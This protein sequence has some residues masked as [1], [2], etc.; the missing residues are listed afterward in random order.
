MRGLLLR[1][2]WRSLAILLFVLAVAAAGGLALRAGL[3]GP[4]EEPSAVA[5]GPEPP[6][7]AP[8]AGPTVLHLPTRRPPTEPGRPHAGRGAAPD[9]GVEYVD[10]ELLV[11]FEDDASPRQ[12]A[13]AVA[14]VDGDLEAHLPGVDVAVVD[15]AAGRTEDAIAALEASPSVEYVE[16]EIVLDGMETLPNDKL[17]QTQ[18]GPKLVQVPAAWDGS[19]GSAATVIAVLDT[20]VDV[21]H[22][23]LRGA[24]ARGY[25][26]VNKDSDPR[27][28]NGH[29]TMVAGIIGARTNNQMGQAGLCWRCRLMPV[30]VLNAKAK[31]T[32]SDVAAGIVWAVDHGAR[33]VVMSLGASSTTKTLTSAVEY[34]LRK[35]VVLVAAAGNAGSGV[36]HHPAATDGVIGVAATTPRDR[37]FGWSNHGRWVQV[38]APGC[39]TAPKPG[40][41]YV[42]FCGTSSA[43]PVVAGVIGLALSSVPGATPAQVERAIRSGVIPVSGGVR[44]GRINATATLHALQR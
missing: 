41:G 11:K 37:L 23:D 10:G 32:S 12:E 44:Y 25:D 33:M 14:R 15:V 27:D 35:G 6:S 34:A 9:E 19:R 4:A 5:P 17:W 13:S 29:G 39:N 28:D 1:R 8:T 20:G 40:G 16:R 24:F 2:G 30:K 38:A 7:A 18:W 3:T 21:R 42:N 43:T 31:G 26:I 22:P 36:P